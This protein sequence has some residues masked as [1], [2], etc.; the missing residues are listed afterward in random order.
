[1]LRRDN[2]MDIMMIQEMKVVDSNINII[3]NKIWI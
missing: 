1:M 2:Y 3:K